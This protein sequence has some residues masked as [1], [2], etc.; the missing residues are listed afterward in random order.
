MGGKIQNEI[1]V[2]SSTPCRIHASN[3]LTLHFF[4]GG[5]AVVVRAMIKG[6]KEDG[7]GAQ[8]DNVDESLRCIGTGAVLGKQGEILGSV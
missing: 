6:G 3:G 2:N 7:E 5:H 4:L 8:E 1:L